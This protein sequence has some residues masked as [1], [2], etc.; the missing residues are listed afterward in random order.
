MAFKDEEDFEKFRE[1]CEWFEYQ[2]VFKMVKDMKEHALQKDE[3]KEMVS[4][5]YTWDK[6]DEVLESLGVDLS[7]P[8]MQKCKLMETSEYQ[9]KLRNKM[10]ADQEYLDTLNHLDECDIVINGMVWD[11]NG[12]ILEWA[13][14]NGFLEQEF[15]EWCVLN[16]NVG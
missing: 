8:Y 16:W 3:I 6:E 5:Y 7:I 15:S 4:R 1:K 14:R 13:I 11:T 12:G 10:E 2:E 9:E